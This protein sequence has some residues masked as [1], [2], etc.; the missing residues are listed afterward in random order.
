MLLDMQA[1]DVYCYV[2]GML[3]S[4]LPPLHVAPS[5]LVLK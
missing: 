3:V 2:G 5:V 4:M 1:G